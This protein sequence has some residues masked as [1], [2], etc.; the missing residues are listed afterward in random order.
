MMRRFLLLYLCVSSPL[1]KSVSNEFI[2]HE[3]RGNGVT[4]C[5]IRLATNVLS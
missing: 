1:S 4:G 3:R 2:T 5:D